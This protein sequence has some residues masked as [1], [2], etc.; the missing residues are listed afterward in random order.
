MYA[1]KDGL[2][3]WRYTDNNH[4]SCKITKTAPRIKMLCHTHTHTYSSTCTCVVSCGNDMRR[5]KFGF[6]LFVD[7]HEWLV[8]QAAQKTPECKFQAEEDE[9]EDWEELL[10]SSSS[11]STTFTHSFSSDESSRHRAMCVSN[12]AKKWTTEREY[13]FSPWFIRSFLSFLASTHSH[14]HVFEG[15]KLP[16]RAKLC[17]VVDSSCGFYGWWKC[18]FNYENSSERE[19]A[20][21]RDRRYEPGKNSFSWAFFCPPLALLCF[22]WPRQQQT[23][24]ELVRTCTLWGLWGRYSAVV[25]R[26]TRSKNKRRRSSMTPLRGIFLIML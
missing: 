7:L 3:Y 24:R 26:T 19:R 14:A 17:D 4:S 25:K 2:H 13:F 9:A 18:Y 22:A 21:H 5:T 12:S 16:S 20:F 6:R 23:R 15:G 1:V 10:R 8:I 11:T